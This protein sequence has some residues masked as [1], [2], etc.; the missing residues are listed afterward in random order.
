MNKVNPAFWARLFW[1]TVY[2]AAFGLT[3][4]AL[5]VYVRRLMGMQPGMDYRAIWAQIYPGAAL[6]SPAFLD[7]FRNHGL[8]GLETAREAGTIVL[9]LGA[10]M[11]AGRQ[12]RERLGIF[13]FTF[14]AWD[15]TYYLWLRL[16]LDFPRS[17]AD[18]DIYFLIPIAW[19]GPVWFPVCVVMPALLVVGAHL[20]WRSAV[21][22]EKG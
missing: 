18:T 22:G 11:A 20:L 15:L 17:L 14:A 7:L 21:E 13:L 6:T 9:L 12:T 8:L 2:G 4:A 19:F 10:A 5:V 1:L 16:L 3:E